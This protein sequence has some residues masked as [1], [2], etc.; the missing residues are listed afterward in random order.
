MCRFAFRWFMLD[1]VSGTL[2]KNRRKNNSKRSTKIL[3]KPP[4][5]KEIAEFPG[6]R[7]KPQINFSLGSLLLSFGLPGLQKWI[8]VYG[9]GRFPLSG[10]RTS[11]RIPSNHFTRGCIERWLSTKR[12]TGRREH[13]PRHIRAHTHTQTKKHEKR[14]PPPS[15]HR[16]TQRTDRGTDRQAQ[17]RRTDRQDQ[18]P[19]TL[20]ARACT[21]QKQ[22]QGEGEKR[23]VWM[24]G[25]EVVIAVE[26]Y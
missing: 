24:G 13:T 21:I 18:V 9:V 26:S 8:G 5:K 20:E 6:T 3:R 11:T 12:T 7:W 2:V 15:T 16:K 23:R 17:E 19:D 1:L 22:E 4:P 14:Q 10:G 25:W